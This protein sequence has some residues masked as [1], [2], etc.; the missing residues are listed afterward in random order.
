MAK[1]SCIV[2][3]VRLKELHK[4]LNSLEKSSTHF[5]LDG[6]TQQYG[7]VI[8]P[9]TKSSFSVWQKAN[10]TGIVAYRINFKN[11][12]SPKEAEAGRIGN[13]FSEGTGQ[14]NK[15]ADTVEKF[16]TWLTTGNNFGEP[17]ATED[18]RQAII[19]KILS[20]PE[21]TPILYYKELGRPSHA[22]IIGYL[23]NHKELLST[24]RTATS[25]ERDIP[26]I[27][28]L[29][30]L[31]R[32]PVPSTDIDNIKEVDK[33]RPDIGI[34]RQSKSYRILQGLLSFERFADVNI[35]K[36]DVSEKTKNRIR[37]A[38]KFFKSTTA[39]HSINNIRISEEEAKTR[40]AETKEL[41]SIYTPLMQD[42]VK[43]VWGVELKTEP[44][45]Y[46]ADEDISQSIISEE[47]P[48]VTMDDILMYVREFCALKGIA[49][50]N[51]GEY[52][53]EAVDYVRARA[54]GENPEV[55]P[56]S[57]IERAKNRLLN[58]VNTFKSFVRESD[59]FFEDH[60]YYVKDNE[61]KE[62]KADISVT[63]YGEY[64]GRRFYKNKYK[65]EQ[66]EEN[67]GMVLG[68]TFDSVARDFFNGELK[69]SYPNLDQERLDALVQSLNNIKLSF[70]R[71]FG[72]GQWFAVSGA[73]PI[74]AEMTD[75]SGNKFTIA[76]EMD[77]VIT[78]SQG[79]LYIYDFKAVNREE[80][81]AHLID[82]YQNQLSL[83]K[84]ILIT[85]FPELA[86]KIKGLGLIVA[87]TTYPK[88][89]IGQLYEVE[90]GNLTIDGQSIQD[91]TN[92]AYNIT[93]TESL[94]G[95]RGYILPLS[96]NS[97][98][99]ALDME[100]LTEEELQALKD[101]PVLGGLISDKALLED[102][103]ALASSEGITDQST[104]IDTD[105]YMEPV[106]QDEIYRWGV[107]LAKFVAHFV[108][109]LQTDDRYREVIFPEE[110]KNS[111]LGLEPIE[112]L[113]QSRLPKLLSYIRVNYF[114]PD[115]DLSNPRVA[116]H[117]WI[118]NHFKEILQASP[119]AFLQAVGCSVNLKETQDSEGVDDDILNSSSQE[120][121]ENEELESWQFDTREI[122]VNAK[123]SQVLKNLFSTLMQ[124]E[125][126]QV[127]ADNELGY[128]WEVVDYSYDEDG[129][130]NF[131]D[132]QTVVNG[133]LDKLH[134]AKSSEEML[135]RLRDEDNVA[136]YPWFPQ[137]AD[138]LEESPDLIPMFYRTFRKNRTV[139]IKS[140]V[141]DHTYTDNEGNS[142]TETVIGNFNLSDA[143][144]RDRLKSS[145]KKNVMEGRASAFLLVKGSLIGLSSVDTEMIEDLQERLRKAKIS[146]RRAKKVQAL[147]E[148]LKAI[149]FDDL[150]EPLSGVRRQSTIKDL[151]D[152]VSKL[153][154][155][156]STMNRRFVPDEDLRQGGENG[157]NLYN[158][159]VSQLIP[160][161]PTE[162]ESTVYDSGKN[163]SVYTEPSFLGDLIENI[164]E[165]SEDEA[166]AFLEDKYGKSRQTHFTDSEGKVHYTSSWVQKM[167]DS[168]SLTRRL[169]HMV[170]TSS[171]GL[172]YR[173][174]DGTTYP[175][176]DLLQFFAPMRAGLSKDTA[177]Y[178]VPTM[179]DKNSSEYIEFVKHSFRGNREEAKDDIA[180]E[181]VNFVLFELRRMRDVFWWNISGNPKIDV[182]SS[183]I[184]E[185]VQKKLREGKKLTFTDILEKGKLR[186]FMKTGGAGFRFF[187]MFNREF[188]N[189]TPFAKR[190]LEY[191]SYEEDADFILDLEDA[192]KGIFKNGM[193]EGFADFKRYL[194]SSGLDNSRLEEFLPV[195]ENGFKDVDEALEEFYW[196][197]RIGSANIL[198]MTILDPAFYKN[199]VEVQ[200]RFAQVHAMTERP[201]VSATFV[202]SDGVRKRLSDGVHRYVIFE[203]ELVDSELLSIAGRFFDEAIARK[204]DPKEKKWLGEQ[205]ERALKSLK[206]IKMTDGQAITSIQGY[207]KKM[208]MLGLLTPSMKEAY[209]RIMKG[210]F[211]NEDLQTV[212]QPVKPFVF[213]WE[214]MQ[215]NG[216][217][218]YSTVQIKDSEYALMMTQVLAANLKS[219]GML[220]KNNPLEVIYD[221]MSQSAYDENGNWNGK[222]IDTVVFQSTIKAG[223]YNVIPI[224][225][226]EDMASTIK[227][228]MGRD[229]YIHKHNFYDWGRQQNVPDHLQDH[230]QAMPS[231]T[232][233]L[234]PAN[235]S[236][237][238][239]VKI[240]NRTIS[241]AEAKKA[242][243]EALS[244]DFR[245]GRD[246]V[247]N[248]FGLNESRASRI[249]KMS[250]FLKD[251]LQRDSRT[252]GEQI[253]AVSLRNGKFN[254]PLGDPS[255]TERYAST[256]FSAV[257]KRINKEDIPGGPTV[258]VSCFG[259]RKPRIVFNE[260]GSLRHLECYITCPSS[261]L[262][263][264]LRL[265]NGLLMSVNEA[266][267]RKIITEDDLKLIAS[268]IPVEQ[269]YSIF[270]IRIAAFLPK[271]LGEQIILP[272]E[273]VALS[274]G[275]FDI[276]KDY[277]ELKY[278]K[279]K[280]DRLGDREK[281]K[282]AIVD[283]Q[284]AFLT[285]KESLIEMFFPQN[286]S[287]LE[288]LATEINPLYKDNPYDMTM[289]EGQYYF[290]N[291][292]MVGKQMVA[293]SASTNVAHALGSLCDLRMKVPDVSF[294]GMSFSVLADNE[295]Y[296]RLD[297]VFSPFDGS[298]VGRSTAMLVGASADNAKNPVIANIGYQKA[299]ANFF[300]GLIRLG[301]PLK[302]VAYLMSQPVVRSIIIESQ[303]SGQSFNSILNRFVEDAAESYGVDTEDFADN[304]AT[305][306]FTD[307]DLKKNLQNDSPDYSF[308]VLQ[309]L[310]VMKD[311]MNNIY[312]VSD[313]L[314]LNS[315]QNAVGPTMWKTLKVKKS[316]DEF[317]AEVVGATSDNG[318]VTSPFHPD[319]MTHIKDRLPFIEELIEVYSEV[320]PQLM[321]QDFI[322]FSRSF[323]G[324]LDYM[325]KKGFRISEMSDKNIRE[326][327]NEFMVYLSTGNTGG[328]TL[329]DGSYKGRLKS[330]YG[331]PAEIAEQ[332][333]TYS[334]FFMNSL[335]FKE[336]SSKK[337]FLPQLK[338]STA[339]M[340][341]ED[342][343]RLS[344]SWAALANPM[345][346]ML[347]KTQ[348]LSDKLIVYNLFRSG[349]MFSPN[350][351]MNIAP[352]IAKN[353]YNDGSYTIISSAETWDY[354]L[355]DSDYLNFLRQRARNHPYGNYVMK[356]SREEM[357]S[358]G[359]HMVKGRLVVNENAV[360]TGILILKTPEGM[361]LRDTN[362]GLIFRKVKKL[363]FGKMG[364]EYNRLQDA[365][366]V[367]TVN[368]RENF[369][370]SKEEFKRIRDL[371]VIGEEDSETEDTGTD[372]TKVEPVE[373]IS[374]KAE[375]IKSVRWDSFDEMLEDP[376]VGEYLE[377]FGRSAD[378]VFSDN[379]G[380]AQETLRNLVIEG[381]GEEKY[382]E[383][384]KRIKDTLDNIC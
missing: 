202:D 44:I 255:M 31:G 187:T 86:S 8:D 77:M 355:E 103:L 326:L 25:E 379:I 122:T 232:R 203:D 28:E 38:Q 119:S 162:Y 249:E 32:F 99:E 41:Y 356:V 140:T 342:R 320:I 127:P 71:R 271:I 214:E 53:D 52:E 72:E 244:E 124:R 347:S 190:V 316:L 221:I 266:L 105:Q 179:S 373:P 363:G 250:D 353:T 306:D 120:G 309:L 354:T 176:S 372:E 284:F 112:I 143:V 185:K 59:N 321:G 96:S 175:I 37:E 166:Q 197:S 10:P 75:Y 198:A 259:Y 314:K 167:V 238:A 378:G 219:N 199:S 156:A 368:T 64:V 46:A 218:F 123:M 161:L 231:Q 201:D 34:T 228:Y 89:R 315:T 301:V 121:S 322:P 138:L 254:I 6:N 217:P 384:E 183:E 159:I 43:E 50:E 340:S 168:P 169:V 104:S 251:M 97:A 130:I 137:I 348:E 277:V 227:D 323:T 58:L 154:K 110:E 63:A 336:K 182:F 299:S 333:R 126:R 337:T 341:S 33:K 170:E 362:E 268:R 107:K 12:N 209:F 117:Q 267:K 45:R 383:L 76:G 172:Q 239:E 224:F 194:A 235:I 36:L 84:K 204:T 68:R 338:L 205:K 85:Q 352:N 303:L 82:R 83:Y 49:Q 70:D 312:K 237:E 274:G 139:Y 371:D 258:Q 359:A 357:S 253:K 285:A 62:K 101:D 114:T 1:V 163:Y 106:T 18:Y 15:G 278:T 136:Q 289:P 178:H 208:G 26:Y 115:L 147:A 17:K 233:A 294:N 304:V 308:K 295:G 365:A 22:T 375:S 160:L 260:D 290:Q 366:A 262:E 213:T 370:K 334:N 256:L 324:L 350:G 93:L 87:Q 35:D 54:A 153:L 380:K 216:E 174:M 192:I 242:Y 16:Y 165:G 246:D 29:K 220:D 332:R 69:E 47:N 330:F 291:Q 21:G 279:S 146:G 229:E 184:P 157:Y 374:N 23:I 132:R 108:R 145:V 2:P 118:N 11:Y 376:I 360:P 79:N 281:R 61:G 234:V 111:L 319:T 215:V 48:E 125:Y 226:N 351:F 98:V 90:D 293:V 343:D 95:N 196:N 173:D 317:T 141:D 349:F 264:K 212:F 133:I 51:W 225:R 269:K 150:S 56:F 189:K 131:L 297:P 247:E 181:A 286:I 164:S 263:D 135:R 364:F 377:E 55:Q 287:V 273:I 223:G 243:F 248:L 283:L 129:I 57:G 3:N 14:I 339:A 211:N 276:D 66:I 92:D 206:G 67:P 335:Q 282:N 78:D 327:F 94:T 80:N 91:L 113:S 381:L 4:E 109:N 102:T 280:G 7:V 9:K 311:T 144:M 193:E 310:Y 20:S 367:E 142:H 27:V 328:R 180:Q 88:G 272:P 148:A 24:P 42:I 158:S 236:D 265:P 73:F 270:P 116:K 329:I 288:E 345:N 300:T 241:G 275:D 200:K 325:S 134:S 39:Y 296:N 230:E 81:A 128:T 346:P 382:S 331:I 257:K 361:F 191:I 195:G 74:A 188:E 19:N 186:S 313:V 155:K 318:K 149:G 358:M 292:N 307:E 261:E 369:M 302:T 13:P 210:K 100:S 245:E 298:N 222:G 151:M 40:A 60:T 171:M 207:I 305:M 344:A 152:S 30:K 5:T 177:R 240:G 65:K 252:T